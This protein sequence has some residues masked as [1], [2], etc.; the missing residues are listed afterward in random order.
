MPDGN[1]DPD[2]LAGSGFDDEVKVI[3]I[4]P[5]G[6][7]IVGGQFTHFN[8]YP[9]NRL[10]RL[11]D[12]GTLDET[13]VIRNG[14]DDNVETIAIQAD[15]N[16]LVGGN[17]LSYQSEQVGRMVR[18]YQNGEIDTTFLIENGFDGS[19]SKITIQHD[20]KI[21][22]GGIFKVFQNIQREALVRILPNGDLDETFN[23][24]ISYFGQSPAKVSE[25]AL[26]PNKNI[27]I[28]GNFHLGD[29]NQTKYIASL[30]SKGKLNP[31]FNSE[32]NIN[33]PIKAAYVQSNGKILIGGSFTR[34]NEQYRP[35]IARLNVDGSL[36]ES[37]QTFGIHIHL[38]FHIGE[39]VQF[40]NHE[41]IVI[42]GLFD[43]KTDKN[44]WHFAILNP[45]GSIDATFNPQSG[46]GDTGFNDAVHE[47]GIQDDGKI[48]VSGSFTS[49]FGM[50]SN[51][52]VRLA[53][54]GEFDP[55]FSIGTG[56]NKEVTLIRIQP[57]GKILVVGEFN[58]FNGIQANRFVRLNTDGSLDESFKI[59]SGF[60]SYIHDIA[61]QADEKILIGGSFKKYNGQNTGGLVRLNPDGSIDKS[62]EISELVV[63]NITAI[64]LHND[65]IYIGGEIHTKTIPEY[66]RNLVRIHL[67]GK[68]D[69]SFSKYNKISRC[70]AIT[71]QSDGKILIGG[72]YGYVNGV[73]TK[74][75][76]RLTYE[77]L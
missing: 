77:G 55:S 47:I 60:D 15:G 68:V 74:S 9:A 25:I 61:I 20:N 70:N 65:L 48:L 7:I 45:T 16:I 39:I 43:S 21:I 29:N 50:P 6:K 56:F 1:L 71:V 23:P 36:D 59:G 54:N 40:P 66:E 11:N 63:E 13:F 57:D 53:E 73:N 24:L 8:G 12:N 67:D 31:E 49:Y 64:C 17:F 38:Q 4:Q 14:F 75:L 76:Y 44:R 52:L 51:N 30:D 58:S 42:G 37:F 28:I 10:V 18:L 32:I 3:V 41:K 72:K 5:D 69:N 35:G 33:G 27:L 46:F 34:I 2:F 22:V 62:L 19:V 26:Q